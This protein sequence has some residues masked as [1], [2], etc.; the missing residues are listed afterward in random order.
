[1][2]L[3]A[4]LF[5]LGFYVYHEMRDVGIRA[6][7]ADGVDLAVHF[8]DQKVKLAARGL[9]HRENIVKGLEM[10]AEAHQFFV[11]GNAVGK[12]GTLGKNTVF[13][14]RYLVVGK[15]LTKPLAQTGVIAVDALLGKDVGC[16]AYIEA[17]ASPRIQQTNH[18]PAEKL[19]AAVAAGRVEETAE[20]THAAL[21]DGANPIA[22]LD[23]MTEAMGQLGERFARGEVFIPELIMAS[24]AMQAASSVLKPMLGANASSL[25]T[26]IIGTVMG[27]MHDI[28][29]NLVAM[30]LEG[31]GFTVVD[32]GTDVYPEDFVDA[33][34]EYPDTKVIA[35]SALL[36][37]T[38]SAMEET[39]QAIREEPACSHVK[40][41]VG[42]APVTAAFAAQIGADAYADNAATAAEE[43]KRLAMA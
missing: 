30:M 16:R 31:A 4:D 19:I 17:Y 25:G 32:L 38:M 5:Q 3:L 22:L 9:V 15:H 29:K 36:T 40:I 24:R 41:M 23:G 34:L 14:G 7:G 1:M 12:D 42:G 37:T 39:V 26:A 18:A 28:G 2:D 20:L 8:L 10:R 35:L 6:F 13:V 11:D 43:A 33:V 21:A 27:D